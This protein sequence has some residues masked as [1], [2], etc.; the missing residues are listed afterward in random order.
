MEAVGLAVGVLSIAGLFTSYIEN[1]NI[2]VRGKSFGEDF[3]LLC[4]QLSL[5]QVRLVIW[6]ESL[7][8]VPSSDEPRRSPY[9]YASR[10]PPIKEPIEAALNHLLKLLNRADVIAERY[11]L[12]DV[13]RGQR[14]DLVNSK[15]MMV[16]R[17][18][19][20]RFKR[21]IRKQQ[22]QSSKWRVTCWAVHDF[23]RFKEL[24]ENITKILDALESITTSLGVLARQRALLT[25][26]IESLSDHSSIVLLQRVG[27]SPDA[28]AS[29]R[30]ASDAASVRLAVLISSSR[31]WHTAKSRLTDEPVK[32][33]REYYV[34]QVPTKADH[35]E[36]RITYPLRT[37]S[38]KV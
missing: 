7:N 26:E 24:V 14:Q 30:N 8:L 33:D 35:K 25:V 38:Y 3:D 36:E 17:E 29:L 11:A 10:Q 16:F 19:F 21:R 9:D 5:Q 20:D 6:G 13:D 12:E 31:S 32:A 15:G 28:P 18:T 27:A 2:I 34:P 4:T 1:F 23:G 22:Q 37:T